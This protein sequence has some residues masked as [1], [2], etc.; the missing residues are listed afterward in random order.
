MYYLRVHRRKVNWIV[1]GEILSMITK[2]RGRTGKID[3]QSKKLTEKRVER[4]EKKEAKE[5]EKAGLKYLLRKCLK[6]LRCW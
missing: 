1:K 4:K 5:K 6:S 3:D 2:K